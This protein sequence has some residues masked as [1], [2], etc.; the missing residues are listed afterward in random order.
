VAT[1]LGLLAAATIQPASAAL[2]QP[3][4]TLEGRAVLPTDTFA[5]GPQSGTDLEDETKVGRTPPFEGQPVGGISAVLEAG[6]GEF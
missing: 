3:E 1:V 2:A 5:E 6:D 4:T